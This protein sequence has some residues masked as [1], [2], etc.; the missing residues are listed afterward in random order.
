VTLVIQENANEMN[1][2]CHRACQRRPRPS[3]RQTNTS[4]YSFVSRRFSRT[5]ALV[6]TLLAACASRGA[7]A[8]PVWPVTNYT[9]PAS[10]SG[11]SFRSYAWGSI[12]SAGT[13]WVDK[14]TVH[15]A[16]AVLEAGV[17]YSTSDG[18]FTFSGGATSYVALPLTVV[19]GG[20]PVSIATWVKPT[21]CTAGAQIASFGQGSTAQEYAY[22]GIADASCHI[23][24]GWGTSGNE[25]QYTSN[26][27]LT[28]GSWSFLVVVF[29]TTGQV[30]VGLNVASLV[31]FETFQTVNSNMTYAKKGTTVATAGPPSIISSAG[32]LGAGQ[33]LTNFFS[34]EMLSFD[35]YML[36]ATSFASALL[37][38]NTTSGYGCPYVTA[39]TGPTSQTGVT[40]TVVTEVG[41]VSPAYFGQSSAGVYPFQGTI[42]D[43]QLYNKSMN[44]AELE[45][46]AA[47]PQNTSACLASPPPPSPFPPPKP[48]SPPLKPPRP[49][50]P[51][52]PPSPPLPPSATQPPSP[53]RPPPPLTAASPPPAPTSY[54]LLDVLDQ[55]AYELYN[56]E[57]DATQLQPCSNYQEVYVPE[58]ARCPA[59]N[60]Y[61]VQ[62]GGAGSYVNTPNVTSQIFQSDWVSN[63]FDRSELNNYR[64][65][66]YVYNNGTH[67]VSVL[68]T[69]P[70]APPDAV[71]PGSGGLLAA[72]FVSVTFDR[73]PLVGTSLN[74]TR[75][76][77][78]GPYWN[79]T[80][81][82]VAPEPALWEFYVAS[83]PP[84]PSP[85]PPQPPPRP[86]GIAAPPR[87]PLPPPGPPPPPDE[88][89]PRAPG[90]VDPPPSPP[91]KPP[92]PPP[93]P[94]GHA[95]PQPPQPPQPSPPPP[96]PPN[97]PAPP[98]T[99][100]SAAS[101]L[102]SFDWRKA[103][104]IFAGAFVASL[105]VG[106]GIW[107]IAIAVMKRRKK[108]K[109]DE[110]IVGLVYDKT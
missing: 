84:P 20:L 94:P 21:K 38:G 5:C 90:S 69:I 43:V 50:P 30:R 88:P 98:S 74:Y 65:W 91:P 109:V 31:H 102:K 80:A 64:L 41:P 58:N 17:T 93:Y 72:K 22:V 66:A 14:S 55:P 67:Y 26:S 86:P 25:Y 107:V 95:P 40:P 47:T 101:A 104:I 77:P 89:P 46:I 79:A 2:A 19:G 1:E 39:T 57:T 28:A 32:Y 63:P 48:P 71:V 59:T 27:T 8:T 82:A 7:A 81:V 13:K 60:T 97:P 56:C 36:D 23:K 37:E 62:T 49:P 9:S 51:P 105:S 15:P 29:Q 76:P 78:F 85:P 42:A 61:G 87:P 108:T 33:G 83:P 16:N 18:S 103:G 44:L 53:P 10:C 68:G 99:L 11:A 6:A 45:A 52:R 75:V 110:D 34:G 92:A 106:V 70:C 73:L 4:S 54:L 12:N 24:A 100:A 35:Y 96:Q 3:H